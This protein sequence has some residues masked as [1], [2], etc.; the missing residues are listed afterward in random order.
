MTHQTTLTFIV[1]VLVLVTLKMSD[2][3]REM[4]LL[5]LL[6]NPAWQVVPFIG[7]SSSG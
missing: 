2:I 1:P 6:Q 3:T 7:E 5:R 4:D